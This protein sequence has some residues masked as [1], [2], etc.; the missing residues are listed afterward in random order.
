MRAIMESKRLPYRMLSEDDFAA[1]CSFLQDAEVMTAWEHAFSD[2]EVREFLA[3]NIRRFQEDG[4]GYL[5]AEDYRLGE[6]V[7]VIGLLWEETPEGRKL[8]VGYILRKKFWGKGYASEGAKACLDYAFKFLLAGE[9]VATIRP[10]NTRSRKVAERLG[11][12][13]QGEVV[14]HYRG[15]D[16]PHL[17]Y[18]IFR[19]EQR[20]TQE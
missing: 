2:E 11:M 6:P 18:R 7:G 8:G 9:V 3:Q 4:K 12:Q 14:K 5:L 16:M 17:I 1:A 19:E 13:V 20:R 10:Q 15:K